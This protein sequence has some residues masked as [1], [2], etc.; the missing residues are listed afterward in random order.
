[1]T[2]SAWSAGA[3]EKPTG[4]YQPGK[5]FTSQAT[6]FANYAKSKSRR[7]T[8]VGAASKRSAREPMTVGA[9]HSLDARGR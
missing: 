5:F 8:F 7:E 9:I 1:M 6:N 4:S 2:R 3:P